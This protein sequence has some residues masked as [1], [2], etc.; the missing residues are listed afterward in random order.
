MESGHCAETRFLALCARMRY[1]VAAAAIALGQPLNA[2]SAPSHVIVDAKGDVARFYGLPILLKISDLKRLPYRVKIGH[3]YA[4][5]ERYT[6]AT[7]NAENDVQVK[8]SF[9]RDR[10]LYVA[11]TASSN[12]VGPKGIG[13]GSLLSDVRSAWPAGR[14]LYGVEENQAFVTFVTGTNVTYLFK[15]QDMPP[16]TFIHRGSVKE[17]PNIRVQSIRLTRDPAPV[18]P[19]CRPAYCL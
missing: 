18:P 15:P 9:G 2:A 11:E 7:I 6:T 13:V 17:V 5:G 4:E 12:A 1:L 3:G 10:K 19:T 16:G 8:V 14:L